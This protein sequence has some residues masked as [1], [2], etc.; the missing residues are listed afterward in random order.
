VLDNSRVTALT[1]FFFFLMRYEHA[2]AAW[3]YTPLQIVVTTTT[4]IVIIISIIFI[5][6]FHVAIFTN[7]EILPDF[8][9]RQMPRSPPPFS[10][11]SPSSARASALKHF[12]SFRNIL[13]IECG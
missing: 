10:C 9:F 3:P 8:Y 4:I 7:A 6:P 12:V 5:H 13:I 2:V 11:L 1:F